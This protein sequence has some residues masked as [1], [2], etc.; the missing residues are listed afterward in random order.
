M[1]ETF[2]TIL[3]TVGR[4][5]IAN[6]QALGTTV[7]FKQMAVGDGGG[8][9]YNPAESQTALKNEVWR[10]NINQVSVDPDNPS[11]IVIETILMATIGGF[12][13]REA[14][15]FD[16]DGDMIAIGKY[17]ETFKPVLD[18]GSAKDLYM[19]MILE[20]SNASSVTLKIDPS[21]IFAT[22]EY[23]D[24]KVAAATIPD[25]TLTRKGKTMLSNEID[26]M[27][28]T[29][30]ATE[31][32]VKIAYDRGSTGITAAADAQTAAATAQ[33]RADAAFTL[34]VEQKVNVV[35]ALNSAGIAATINDSWAQLVSKMATVIKATGNAIASQVR[36]G[37]IF[38]NKDANGLVGTLT[39]QATAAQTITP[40]T[41]NIVK[42]AGIY[43]GPITVL[44]DPDLTSA[45]IKKGVELFGVPGAYEGKK[46]FVRSQVP[47]PAATSM[48]YV[49]G[50][51]AN[52]YGVA[53][54]HDNTTYM[55]WIIASVHNGGSWWYSSTDKRPLEIFDA[56]GTS[57]TKY[58]TMSKYVG[59]VVTVTNNHF[60]NKTFNI[61][62]YPK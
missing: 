21:A 50:I 13:V 61:G 58:L 19:R 4:A 32:A 31:Q 11:W 62:I 51:D 1:A 15:I 10:G 34:G 2:Y 55:H 30:A 17:P 26:G 46:S 24:Q 18:S 60:Q 52:D 20:V 16:V 53:M 38:S 22:R 9:Y 45:N 49:T 40:S 36:A 42:N 3:T 54:V 5:K 35:A 57:T 41:G 33:T 44:G 6:A 59:D 28:E 37:A 27:R 12:T 25:A 14:G 47:L 48:D 29:V 39:V 7:E 23:V 56:L 8:S 43:D